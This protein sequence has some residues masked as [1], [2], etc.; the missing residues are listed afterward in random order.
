MNGTPESGDSSSMLEKIDLILDAVEKAG[1]LTL[2]GVME[3]TG[4]ARSTTHRLL[5]QLERKRWL[6]RVGTNYELGVRLFDLGTKGVRNHW[7]YRQALPSL[8][9]LH[10]YTGSVVHL[11]YLDSA[12][13][14]FW[15]KIGPGKFGASVPSR[16]GHHIPAN[17]TASGKALLAAQ[18]P[19]F[20]DGLGRFAPVTERTIFSPSALHR[21][22][23][24][25]R[26]RG[27]ATDE[28][29]RLPGVGCFATTVHAGGFDAKDAYRTTAAISV[30]V[31]IERLDSRL[32]APLQAAKEQILRNTRVN[33]MVAPLD[34]E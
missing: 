23:E 2:S 17:S 31:P 30:C 22:L 15:D 20:V 5:T 19:G 10:A 9:W 27:Y 12:D 26:K 6:F 18:P 13:A 21:E 8:H 1:Y 14:V 32:L 11:T 16:I 4:L 33:P 34:V 7:F 28:G 3:R 25:I 29:E 24:T